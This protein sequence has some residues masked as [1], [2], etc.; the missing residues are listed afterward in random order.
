MGDE[1]REYD[2]KSLNAKLMRVDPVT[3]KQSK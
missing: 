3:S 2:G 1:A